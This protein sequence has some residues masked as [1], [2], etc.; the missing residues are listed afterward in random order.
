MRGFVYHCGILATVLT[1][2]ALLWGCGGN[3]RPDDILTQGEVVDVLEEVYIVEEKVS[4]LGL[5]V[6]SATLVTRLM[7]SKVIERMGIADSTWKKSYVWYA[8]RPEELQ[9]IYAMLIDSLQLREQRSDIRL[10]QE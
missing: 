10:Q 3:D 4:R 5:K 1:A 9:T 7:T 6:D 2:T 8:N